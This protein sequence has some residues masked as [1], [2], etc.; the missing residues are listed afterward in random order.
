MPGRK[1]RLEFFIDI[2]DGNIKVNALTLKMRFSKLELNYVTF[3]MT[4]KQIEKI[5]AF[6][7]N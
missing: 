4:L 6:L 5:G 3:L 1:E 7:N 2:R